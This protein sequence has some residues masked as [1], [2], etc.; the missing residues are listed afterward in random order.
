[1]MRLSPV[2]AALAV[3]L[4]TFPTPARADG[5]PEA[6]K[7]SAM[8]SV[9]C[10]AEAEEAP[11]DTDDTSGA[12][13]G[14]N[15]SRTSWSYQEALRQGREACRQ[16][17]VASCGVGIALA[18]GGNAPPSITPDHAAIR[19]VATLSLQPGK[20]TVGPPPE[21]NKWK[22][23]AVGYPLWIWAEGNLDPA[24]VSRSVAGLSVS[25]DAS[26]AKIVY[27]LGDGTTITCGPGT[28]WRKGSVPAGTPSP[29][30]GHT[31]AKP[32]LPKGRYTI[33]AT[34]HWS[35]AWTAGGQSGTIPFTQ[36]STT[37]LPVG[38]VQTLVR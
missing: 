21:L 27:D 12:N 26:L 4:L 16:S 24:P 17:G 35:V 10:V 19:A 2:L 1:M 23:A 22:M 32:S 7:G 38:E 13:S 30:C 34:T 14:G 29:D 11:D 5:K 6:P 37:T 25:L 15:Y 33:T 8:C 9:I 18:A 3:L 36:T 28:P 31:Y 20:P